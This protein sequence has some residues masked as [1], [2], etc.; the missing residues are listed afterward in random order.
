MERFELKNADTPGYLMC[1][2]QHTGL[3]CRFQ[4]HKFNETQKTIVVDF[5]MFNRARDAR[6]KSDALFCA[7][8]AREMADW[9]LINHPEKLS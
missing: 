9:L 4:E 8:A 5:A 6:K 1:W 7:T 2:D 3:L